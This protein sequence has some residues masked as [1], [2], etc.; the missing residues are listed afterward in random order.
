MLS[1][2]DQNTC[3]ELAD[4]VVRNVCEY[5]AANPVLALGLTAGTMIASVAGGLFW[6]HRSSAPAA[7]TTT[8]PVARLKR[9]A[10][11]DIIDTPIDQSQIVAP[12]TLSTEDKMA[13]NLIVLGEL[14]KQLQ[15]PETAATARQLL[16]LRQTKQK[17]ID[18]IIL[19]QLGYAEDGKKKPSVRM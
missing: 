11:S 4:G 14:N 7:T 13:I 9:Q 6:S 12:K 2:I 19:Q 10:V 16:L 8:Q 3:S 15:D 5:A 18:G 1:F 17:E